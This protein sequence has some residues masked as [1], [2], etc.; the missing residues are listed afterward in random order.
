[1]PAAQGAGVGV[2]YAEAGTDPLGPAEGVADGE[3][4]ADGA[5][6]PDSD[7]DAVAV[8]E[9]LGVGVGSGITLLGNPA[10]ASA[11]IST[12][13]TSTTTDHALASRSVAGGSAPR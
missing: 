5:V 11:T 10:N 4:V 13:S 8:G 9:G 1:M 3:L 12:K 2:L 6:L 7:G